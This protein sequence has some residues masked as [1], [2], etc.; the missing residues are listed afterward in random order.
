M[1]TPGNYRFEP[2]MTPETPILRNI[3][4]DLKCAADPA[5]NALRD[6]VRAFCQDHLPDEIRAKVLLNQH[7]DKSDHVRWQRLLHEAELLVAHWPI[8]YGGRGWTRR[9]RWMFENEIYRAG[10]PWLVPFGITYVA[11]VIYTYGDDAQKSRWLAPTAESRLWWAQGYS[12]PNAGSD[13]ASIRTRA[14]RDGDHFIVNGHKTWTTMAQ[15]ADMMFALVRTEDS[16]RPQHGIS[17]M[18]IDLQS[19]GISVRPIETIDGEHHVNEI[20]LDDVRV[21]VENLVGA[22]GGGWTCAKFLLGNERL[23]AAEVGKAQRLMAQLDAFMAA[24]SLGSGPLSQDMSWQR[25]RADL[26]SRIL[27]LESLSYDLLSQAEAGRDPG[28]LASILKLVGSEL[29][30]AITATQIDAL[31]G[32]GLS[33]TPAL[34]A[35]NSELDDRL[36]EGGSGAIAEYLHDRAATIY[37]GSSEIQRNIIA[38]AVLG[39]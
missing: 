2:K 9:Q 5:L 12:E 26:D 23:L 32:R 30:Q 8:E 34:L 19:P 33:I 39:L 37:G 16:V 28:S 11:P 24:P 4:T 35:G 27:A 31:A 17:F 38:K 6:E 21:P 10:S 22:E 15:W 29:I 3:I 14:V 25:R 7:L 36:P 1:A 13:L 20:F 18:L